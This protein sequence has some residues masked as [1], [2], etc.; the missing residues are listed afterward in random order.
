MIVA[1]ES[2]STGISTYRAVIK[3]HLFEKVY[4]ILMVIIVVN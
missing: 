3:R 2:G 4:C 1:L